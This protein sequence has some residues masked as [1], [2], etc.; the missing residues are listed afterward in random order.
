MKDEQLAKRRA[1]VRHLLRLTAGTP[2]A[3]SLYERQLLLHYVAG[4]LSID[5][6]LA[7]I[8][9]AQHSQA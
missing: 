3:L 9:E 1:L 6:V 4:T 8:E 5:Q 2:N 7:L